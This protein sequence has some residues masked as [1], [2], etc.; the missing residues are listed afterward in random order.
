MSEK[1]SI[2]T[3]RELGGLVDVRADLAKLLVL[4]DDDVDGIPVWGLVPHK[5]YIPG[6]GAGAPYI[7]LYTPYSI[8][9]PPPLSEIWRTAGSEPP[10]P[11]LL[12][13]NCKAY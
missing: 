8:E 12:V 4:P 13:F 2:E 11:D 10:A 5:K 9:R 3:E 7:I 1:N 6:P